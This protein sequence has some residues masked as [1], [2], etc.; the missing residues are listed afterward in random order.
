MTR[1]RRQSGDARGAQSLEMGAF[2]RVWN[3]C[4]PNPESGTL[5]A[6]TAERWMAHQVRVRVPSH[7]PPSV[8]VTTR[9]P[10][11]GS[12]RTKIMG[13]QGFPGPGSAAARHAYVDTC[14][15]F[16]AF[17]SNHFVNNLYGIGH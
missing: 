4:S 9:S 8:V 17:L 14:R 5:V 3:P 13:G 2:P 15:G 12:L 11:P 1:D 16:A 6:Q 10:R 7:T